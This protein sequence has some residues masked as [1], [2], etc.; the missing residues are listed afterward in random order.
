MPSCAAGNAKRDFVE[1]MVSLLG[2]LDEDFLTDHVTSSPV[3][4]CLVQREQYQTACRRWR[5][6]ATGQ[7]QELHLFMLMLD[8]NCK[9]PRSYKGA[10]VFYLDNLTILLMLADLVLQAEGQVS[11]DS[12]DPEVAKRRAEEEEEK[13]L[14]AIRSQGEAVTPDTFQRWRSKFDA[15]G[16]LRGTKYVPL[17]TDAVKIGCAVAH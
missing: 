7:E 3:L 6:S 17:T 12:I 13:R 14:A 16:L 11:L 5:S 15:E 10:M 9:P 1:G 4:S 8:P 2:P